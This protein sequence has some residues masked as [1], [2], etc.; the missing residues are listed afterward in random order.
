[1]AEIVSAYANAEGGTVV[2]G[3]SDKTRKVEGVDSSKRLLHSYAGI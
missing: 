3:I 1:M 2:I